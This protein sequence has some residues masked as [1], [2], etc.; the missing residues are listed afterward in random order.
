MGKF[1]TLVAKL[2]F[3]AFTRKTKMHLMTNKINFTEEGLSHLL[4]H[5]KINNKCNYV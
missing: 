2:Q 4:A 1:K 3:N 5:M